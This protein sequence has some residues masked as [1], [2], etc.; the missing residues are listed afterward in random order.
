[1]S[2]RIPGDFQQIS[3]KPTPP[4]DGKPQPS[5]PALDSGGIPNQVNHVNAIT[6]PK[7]GGGGKAPAW[8]GGG[9]KGTAKRI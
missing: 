7:L 1:M 2:R 6:N 3:P 4:P 8:Q 5:G 9:K